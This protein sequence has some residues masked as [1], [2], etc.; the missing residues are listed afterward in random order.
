MPHNIQFDKLHLS[1][2]QIYTIQIKFVLS[3]YK[4]YTDVVWIVVKNKVPFRGNFELHPIAVTMGN[5][6]GMTGVWSIH[7][8]T[9]ITLA[10]P[11][12]AYDVIISMT[13]V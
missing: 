5:A 10:G 9:T 7:L 1:I 13:T 2:I 4:L 3:Y 12:T 8:N 11:V 6:F